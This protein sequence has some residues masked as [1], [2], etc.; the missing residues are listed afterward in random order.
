MF[1]KKTSVHREFPSH[2]QSSQSKMLATPKL[3]L[4]IASRKI[5]YMLTQ[6][7]MEPDSAKRFPEKINRWKVNGQVATSPLSHLGKTR[8]NPKLSYYETQKSTVFPHTMSQ[9]PGTLGTKIACDHGCLFPQSYGD[10][11][12][13]STHVILKRFPWIRWLPCRPECWI[14]TEAE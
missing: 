7:F 10:Y 11:L 12:G 13:N 1:D 6:Q 9:N 2:V 4:K 5:V 8:E 3:G 14:T